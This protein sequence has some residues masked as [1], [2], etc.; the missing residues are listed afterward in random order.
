M[1]RCVEVVGGR[2]VVLKTVSKGRNTQQWFFDSNTRT[3]K[4][5]Q[6]KD[7]SFDIQNAGRSNN[8]QVWKTNAR[9]FQ[10]F[11]YRDGYMQNEKG[12]V[13]DVSGGHDSE[14]RNVILWN[15]HKGLNQQWDIVYVDEMKPEPKK[16]ELNTEFGFYVERPFYIISQMAKGR[17]LDRIN[18]NLVI[19]T[20]N[21]FN[22][23]EW[24][25][26][27]PSKTVRNKKDNRSFDIQSAGRSNNMQVWNTNSGWF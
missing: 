2:N 1:K 19:K 27:Q 20:K 24:F 7:R 22:T 12:K 3:I 5:Q 26:H 6:F 15:K 25:F 4:S 23:Q 10:L 13:F 14:N 16:G 8:L 18:N 11:R 9:W 21:G 17:Y